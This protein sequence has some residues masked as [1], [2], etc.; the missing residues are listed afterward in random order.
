MLR[1]RCL[2]SLRKFASVHASVT[3]HFNLERSLCSRHL[4][5]AHRAAALAEGCGLCTG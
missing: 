2:R 1:F 3:N 4:F 5:K